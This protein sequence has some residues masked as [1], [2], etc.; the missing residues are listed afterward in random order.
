MLFSNTRRILAGD[1]MMRLIVLVMLIS[2]LANPVQSKAVET[3]FTT[4]KTVLIT[5]SNRGIGLG[6]VEYYVAAGWNV[7]ATARSPE[8]A[9]DLIRIGKDYPQLEIV[10]LDVTDHS[11]I[12]ELA[13]LYKNQP[14]DVLI[15]N[16]GIKPLNRGIGVDYD[17]ARQMFEVNVW[18]AV[19]MAEA[20]M[21]HLAKSK[22][23]KLV[24]ISSWLGSIGNAPAQPTMLNYRAS[25]TAL[26]SYMVGLSHGTPKDGVIVSLIHPGGVDV[27]REAVCADLS[28]TNV[29]Q[30]LC[31]KQ[32]VEM[33]MQT[34]ESLTMQ[35]NGK[36]FNYRPREPLSW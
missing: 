16:A 15:N 25:K 8:R 13:A 18:G 4:A 34:I 9:A 21:P 26:N 24:N 11:R 36:F 27:R 17:D 28:K 5:G 22:D 10:Q 23:K 33:M 12:D 30:R 14:I 20:F 31:V 29:R 35:D 7:I 3:E 32:S 2:G 1:K 19:K 6:F